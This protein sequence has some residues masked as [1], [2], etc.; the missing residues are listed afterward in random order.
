MT[1][2]YVQGKTAFLK[3]HKPIRQ[4]PYLTENIETEVVIVGGGVTGSIV[5]YYL[6]KA[7]V[8]AV[9]L[10]KRRIAHGSSSISTSLLQY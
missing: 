7:G 5:S 8:K 10:E 9:V 1:E 4:Y 2:H 3:M 6:S